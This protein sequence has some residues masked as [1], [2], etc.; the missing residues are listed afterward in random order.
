[1]PNLKISQF[2]NITAGSQIPASQVLCIAQAGVANF[3]MTLDAMF[4]NVG[5][6][7][8][9][10]QVTSTTVSTALS[11]TNLGIVVTRGDNRRTIQ[12]RINTDVLPAPQLLISSVV[13]PLEGD[14]INR[15]TFQKSDNGGTQAPSTST[16]GTIEFSNTTGIT[17]SWEARSLQSSGGNGTVQTWYSTRRNTASLVGIFGID[18]WGTFRVSR[19][20]GPLYSDV[21]LSDPSKLAVIGNVDALNDTSNVCL[22][23]LN[24][25]TFTNQ[26]NLLLQAVAGQTANLFECKTSANLK[27]LQITTAGILSPGSAAGVDLATATLPFKD[28][29]LAGSS[30]TPGTNNFRITGTATAARVITLPDA[31]CT[32]SASSSALTSGRVVFTT[33]GGL[34]TDSSRLLWNG[35]I[36]S[37]AQTGA[38]VVANGV[39]A[40]SSTTNAQFYAVGPNAGAQLWLD[41]T[42]S[43][44]LRFGLQGAGDAFEFG[45]YSVANGWRYQALGI[46]NGA[47]DY[48][49]RLFASGRVAV[50][51][52]SHLSAALGIKANTASDVGAVIRGAASQTANLTEWQ[53]SAGTLLSG[54]DASGRFYAPTALTATTATSGAQTLPANPDGF[55]LINVNGTQ[56]KVPY[57]AN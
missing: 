3:Q 16:L 33:T 36:L 30:G 27:T 46:E 4:S 31:T 39:L 55:L 43:K 22:H 17:A 2:T 56:K 11:A 5:A 42:P 41:A 32:L 47:A 24:A 50:N 20:L 9:T 1:M 52:S 21:Q 26:L 23:V 28:F 51:N 7:T 40:L 14:N 6:N 37:I 45:T 54:I 44:A 15:I 18:N 10:G 38:T 53:N 8:T 19:N 35:E 12:A 57:Y 34:L 25:T 29:Y 48:T 49:V 13:G